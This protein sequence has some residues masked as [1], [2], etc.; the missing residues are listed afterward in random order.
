MLKYSI[1]KSNTL[2]MDEL[3]DLYQDSY[4]M[5]Q[6]AKCATQNRFH[7]LDLKK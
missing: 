5:M 4:L 6:K 7:Y 3:P 2:T 1:K